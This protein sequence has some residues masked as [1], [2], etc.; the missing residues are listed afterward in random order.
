M[1]LDASVLLAG[2]NN[3]A[4]FPQSART[5]AELTVDDRFIDPL[6]GQLSEVLRL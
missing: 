6:E 2:S 1:L 5:V 4:R 3:I